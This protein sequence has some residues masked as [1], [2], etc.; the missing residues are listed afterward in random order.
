M[1]DLSAVVL[2][3]GESTTGDALASIARQTLP[4]ADVV[5][6]DGVTPFHK[7]LNSGAA[8]INSRFFVQVDSDMILDDDCF[9]ALREC[10][11]DE[12]GLVVGHLG[13]PMIG[14]IQGVKLFRTECF[15]TTQ[16]R[17][18]VS[19]D[20]DFAAEAAGAGW[21]TLFALDYADDSGRG[22]HTFGVHRP[23]YTPHYTFCKYTIEGRRYRYRSNPRG[24]LWNMKCLRRSGHPMAVIA[25]L[26]LGNGIFM[27]EDGDMLTRFGHSDD[28]ARLTAFMESRDTRLEQDAVDLPPAADTPADA[29]LR[30]M[31]RALYAREKRAFGYVERLLDELRDQETS[32]S[33]WFEIGLA[34]GLL[35]SG[36]GRNGDADVSILAQMT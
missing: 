29:F 31:H 18:T 30:G 10:V 36:G 21:Q 11:V 9:A 23:D 33:W 17:N 13:D 34:R 7:A 26:A 35:A 16:F 32:N 4:P 14:R 28:Y 5:V 20:T 19:P 25:R 6:V 27:D 3:L 24:L 2:T 8:R 1:T 22:R 15:R 12:V